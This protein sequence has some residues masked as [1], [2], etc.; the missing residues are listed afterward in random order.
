MKSR[1]VAIFTTL[2]LVLAFSVGQAKAEDE[3]V[4]GMLL[5]MSGQSKTYGKLMSQ[6]ALL[7]AEEINA[8]GGVN[9]HKI[10]IEIGDHKGG[11]VKATTNEFSRMLNLYNVKAVLSSFSPPTIAAQAIAEKSDVVLINGGGWSPKLIGKK[12]LWNTRLTGDAVGAAILKV[13]FEDGHRKLAMI[14][15]NET[16]GIDTANSARETW[17]GLGGTVVAEERFDI[18]ATNYSTQIAKIRTVRPDALLSLAFGKQQGVVIK[19]ARDFGYSG[20]MYG[21][22]FLP[23][24]AE[25]AGKAI[26]GFKFAVDE[27]DVNSTL[28]E[29]ATYVKAYRAKYNE[30]PEFYG[31][32]YYEATYL[33]AEVMKALL[34]E[35]KPITGANIDAKIREIKSFFS[36]YGGKMTLMPNGTVSK[37][38]AV[39]EVRNGERHLLKRVQN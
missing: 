10:R 39:F 9:G 16:S 14:Y 25:V 33:F 23:E 12:Y 24:N 26:E 7:A 1:L 15:R 35:G 17:K 22:D 27:F 38:I 21:I 13:A 3:I 29:T 11:D 6:G 31:A 2:A 18:E 30:E 36:V 5:A 20:P 28:P 4:I 19:Q 8:K 37:P 32:N 34:D